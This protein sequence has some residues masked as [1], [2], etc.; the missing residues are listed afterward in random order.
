MYKKRYAAFFAGWLVCFGALAVPAKRG[1][2][3]VIQPD[4]ST[5]E[6]ILCGDEHFN[7]VM[8]TDSIVLR[9]DA[10]GFYRPAGGDYIG[11]LKS[12]GAE[13]EGR[14]ARNGLN[15]GEVPTTGTLR[16]LVILA[17][18]ADVGFS[19]NNGKEHFE[20]LLNEEGYSDNGA[21][22]SVRDYYVDQSYG[23]FTPEFDVAGPVRLS[24]NMAY[25]G[26]DSGGTTDVNAYRMIQEACVLADET[27]GVDFSQYDNNGDGKVDLVYVVY[28]GYAQSN[29][30]SSVTVWPHM[31]FLSEY[32]VDLRLDGVAV[33]RYACSA[34]R[35][36]ISG[37]V[38]TGIGLICHEFSHTLGLPDLYDV[39]GQSR[40]MNM[41][42]WDVMD[43]GCYNNSARTPAGYSSYEKSVLGWIEPETLVEKQSE[44]TL[45]PLP[46]SRLAYRLQS[47]VNEKEYFLL[48]TRNKS[49]KWDRYLPGEGMLVIHVDYD[50]DVWDN[51]WVNSYGNHRV[52][53]VPANGDFSSM[54]DGGSTPF[55][56]TGNVTVWSDL[57]EPSTLFN[58]GTALG[59][60]LTGIVYDGENTVFDYGF[61]MESP[62]ITEPTNVTETGFRANWTAVEG[63]K[64]YTVRIIDRGSGD[65]RTFEKIVRNRYT[66][67]GLDPDA[68]YVYAVQAQSETLISDFSEEA[69][70]RLADYSGGISSVRSDSVGYEVYSLQGVFL[71]RSVDGLSAGVYILKSAGGV[72]KIC[73]EE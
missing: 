20:R 50:K 12:R 14:I 22:G 6:V 23:Q 29:G 7:Y 67:T 18:F 37:D 36:G 65:T 72:S 4:G 70:I 71:G 5:I 16:G 44:V 27:C 21:T 26:A 13:R 11:M 38:I 54:T 47:P 39:S 68:T 57:T 41:G 1:V 62:V 3:T 52:H 8:D 24:N 53:L 9:Q 33:D 49:D 35:T 43:S 30:A 66:F 63:A 2:H 34:E 19:E 25:Y 48:E 58:D 45:P 42:T 59:M 51:N 61:N 10:D 32:G 64:Y 15:D 69:S 17:E 60:P 40:S 56:G 46:S 31:W 73:I 55:P 28:A